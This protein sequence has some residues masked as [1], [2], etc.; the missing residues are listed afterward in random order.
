MQHQR[1]DLLPLVQRLAD[2]LRREGAL[3]FG[4]QMSLAAR[5]AS[6]H[7]EV[8]RSERARFRVVLLD[9][10][11]DTGHAQRVLLSSLF[12]G[13]EDAGLAL[14]AVGDPMQSIYG[15]RGASAANLPRFATDFPLADGTPAPKLELLTS[16]RNPPEAL[17]L[18]NMISEP[19]RDRGVE[20]SKLRRGP[21]PSPATCGSPFSTP[22][23]PSAPG[24]PTGSPSSTRRPRRRREAAHRGRAGAT[25]RRRRPD[26]GGTAGA[27]PR[28][29][30]GG[31]RW[32]A[33]HA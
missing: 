5:V 15:W 14:T 25:Q 13:G 4:S 19:L 21:R 10:Y 27:G 1:L 11:Q 32:S 9:E 29:G 18:A 16:W 20:V 30:G 26:R 2:T 24:W 28:R 12:G 23:R 33:A 8:G 22:W 17:E 7:P 3:D 6:E 31:P